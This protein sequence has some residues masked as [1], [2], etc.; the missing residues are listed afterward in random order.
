MVT[1]LT[2]Q[3]S[4]LNNTT[5]HREFFSANSVYHFQMELSSA[6]TLFIALLWKVLAYINHLL[7]KCRKTGCHLL[8]YPLSSQTGLSDLISE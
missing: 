7:D 5:P 6:L 8:V 3:L 1:I 2:A 4:K